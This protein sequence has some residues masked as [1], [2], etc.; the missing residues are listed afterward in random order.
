[1]TV[2]ASVHADADDDFNLAEA[3]ENDDID[4]VMAFL[5]KQ[6]AWTQDDLEQLESDLDVCNPYDE[7]CTTVTMIATLDSWAASGVTVTQ[8]AHFECRLGELETSEFGGR[9]DE[10]WTIDGIQID[11]DSDIHGW[12]ENDL[13]KLRGFDRFIPRS[14]DLKDVCDRRLGS[15]S[16]FI[17]NH[18]AWRCGASREIVDNVC[19]N[20]CSY[21]TAHDLLTAPER[22]FFVNT[23]CL[24][25]KA[26]GRGFLEW[27]QFGCISSDDDAGDIFDERKDAPFS[28]KL[29]A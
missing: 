9:S 26:S 12:L 22:E 6:G 18:L 29:R 2:T 1:M 25:F 16:G 19:E 8:T 28:V 15:S 21:D 23:L 13:G 5:K 10:T 7:F 20:D 17:K 11:Q 14:L 3:I 24:V 4:A 27:G